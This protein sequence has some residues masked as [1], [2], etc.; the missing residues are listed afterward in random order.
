MKRRGA[1]LWS[2]HWFFLNRKLKR[3]LFISV[4][5]R[6]RGVGRSWTGDEEFDILDLGHESLGRSDKELSSER[7]FG[8]EGG[9][10]AGARALGLEDISDP[11]LIVCWPA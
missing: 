4:W 3:I 5:S 2:S 1:L 6:T 7:F 8:W 10:G 11:H 9:V